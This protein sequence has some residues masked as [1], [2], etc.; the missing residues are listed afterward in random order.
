[1]LCTNFGLIYPIGYREDV[2]KVKDL[3]T[4]DGQQVT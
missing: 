4:D 2:K 1:M 3:Q